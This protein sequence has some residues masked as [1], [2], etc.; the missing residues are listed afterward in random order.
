MKCKIKDLEINY[1]V[2]GEGKP[3]VMIH[4]YYPDHRLMLGCMEPIFEDMKGWKRIYLD[5]PGMG[6]TKSRDWIINSDVMLDVVLKFIDSVIPNEKFIV[7]GESYGSYIARGIIHKR[8]E[9]VEGMLLI[10]PL[11]IAEKEK[12]D[13][14][15]HLTI[16][17]DEGLLASISPEAAEE[18]A[19]MA[20]VQSKETWDR[21]NNEILSG[22]LSADKSFLEKFQEN[23]YSFSFDVDKLAAPYTKPVLILTGRQDSSVGYRDGWNIIENFPRG[24]YVVLDRAGHNLHIEQPELFNALVKEWLDRVQEDND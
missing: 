2:H 13:R 19:S 20:V 6:K 7:A 3:I 15:Q 22:V 23:G 1:E 8:F 4:G 21:F 17:R 5:L 18:F 14:P 16:V 11:I 12:R 9:Q 24:T 10:C